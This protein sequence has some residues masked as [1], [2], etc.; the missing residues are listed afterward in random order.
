MVVI[1]FMINNDANGTN[2]MGDSKAFEKA[3]SKTQEKH[4]VLHWRTS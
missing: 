2:K 4:W 3:D 1:I